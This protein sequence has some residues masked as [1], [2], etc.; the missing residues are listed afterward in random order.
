[1]DTFAQAI[2]QLAEMLKRPAL[3]PELLWQSLM[4]VMQLGKEASP[5]GRDTMLEQVATLMTTTNLSRASCVAVSCGALVEAGAEPLRGLTIV[6]KGTHAALAGA[7]PFIEACQK[8]AAQNGDSAEQPEACV[9]ARGE[10]VAGQM[11]REAA[12]F[13]AA[14]RFCQAMTAFLSR[15]REARRLAQADGELLAD[16]TRMPFDPGFV[17]FLRKLLLVLDDEEMVVLHPQ[18]RRGYR[19]QISGIGDNFQLHTLLADALI[20]DPTQGWL[21]GKRPDARVAALAKDA[22]FAPEEMWDLPSVEGTFN[23]VNW[24][25]L[26]PDETL[27]E[28]IQPDATKHWIWNEGI[29]ADIAPFEGQ[30]VIL[31]GPPPYNRF[32]NAGRI[33][34]G[35]KADLRVLEIL[36]PETVQQWLRRIASAPR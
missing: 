26:Q 4:S 36:S 9:E 3:T 12:A 34:P 21:P 32:W 18:L 13:D 7:V 24:H 8:A 19:I 35:M 6:M 29:P 5:A 11:P 15:S 20:G 30:R 31:L 22:P 17:E 16:C 25:G 27:P 2:E 10:Q 33:F 28:G 1:M 14:P 23:L